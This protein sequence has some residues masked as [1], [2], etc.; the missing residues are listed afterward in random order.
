MKTRCRGPLSLA[1]VLSATIALLI[2]SAC[3][4]DS[5]PTPTSIPTLTPTVVPQSPTTD[6]SDSIIAQLQGAQSRWEQSGITSYT[7]RASWQCFCLKEYAAQVDV[8]V[9]NNQVANVKFAEPNFTGD[10]PEPERFGPIQDRFDFIRDAIEQEASRIDV[11]FHP[12]FGYPLKVFVDFD[13]RTADEERGFTI[14]TLSDGDSTGPET[15][16]RDYYDALSSG[17]SSGPHHQDS[18][19][20]KIRESTAGVSRKPSSDGKA[21]GSSS[22]HL[23]GLTAWNT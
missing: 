11:Q 5:G 6:L 16:V 17:N 7:Y 23:C 1:S 9:V 21:R 3:G 19:E 8:Q 22:K 18:G 13:E 15:T 20:A 12:E 14:L 4:S 2:M 10:V